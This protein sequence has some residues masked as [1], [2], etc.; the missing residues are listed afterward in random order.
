MLLTEYPRLLAGGSHCDL[1]QQLDT[2]WRFYEFCQPDHEIYKTPD[3]TRFKSTLPLL[4][5]GDEGRYLK[6]GNFMVCTIESILGNDPD[7]KKKD[8]ICSCCHDPV[9]ERYE[10]IEGN[11]A[12]ERP[13][14]DLLH[15]AS[16]QHV[17]DSGNEFLSKF[18][19]FGMSSL[20]Y[21]KDKGLLKEAFGMVAKDLTQ[22]HEVGLSV[23]GHQFFAATIGCKGDLKFH[24]QIGNL[25][26]S[27]YNV[28]TKNENAIC[29]L[30]LAGRPGFDFE[31]CSDDPPWMRTMFAEKP[32]PEGSAPCMA[33]IP[34]Q[35][36][37]PESIFRLDLFHCF[38]C[39]L[40]RDLTGSSV[41]M[42]AQLGYFD[43]ES[44]SK[45]N[46]PAR[47]ERA[48]GWFHLWCK[49]HQK[50]A[51][52]HS[53]SKALLNYKNKNSF[54]WFNVKGSD[55]TLLTL[56]LL[57]TIKLSVEQGGRGYPRF[58]SAL[59]E[60]LESAKVVFEILHSHSL[61]LRR[62]CAQRVQHHLAVVVRGY[63]VLAREAKQLNVVSYGL[64]PKL[65]ALDHIG[66]DLG[67]Q[68]KDKAP[69]VLNPLA[70]SC[71]ANESVVGHVSRLA[72]R[73]DSRTC[74]TRVFDRLCIK[75]KG[76]LS[77][78][79]KFKKRCK[80]GSRKSRP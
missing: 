19:L 80:H 7:N 27:Y 74:G 12:C 72:R 15:V 66:K 30:C 48:H 62:V 24:H 9:L 18:L 50:S 68:L 4:V 57:H 69:L 52:L 41:V 39:D 47:L 20:I 77:K 6:K 31:N 8:A 61:W 43:S 67:K 34:F 1:H 16:E 35:A 3:R 53:F 49:A 54:A 73:V 10:N 44:D 42:M 40:G 46:L 76:L 22:L 37:A 51:A 11:V 45:F 33:Q 29:S 13:L 58:E 75:V 70:W 28:G 5:H 26:R 79:G 78:Y 36:G 38:K 2:F 59:L 63:K 55:N 32:W 23:N 17:N 64:K 14:G 21:K 65:H 71:E 60:T 25:S 56:W